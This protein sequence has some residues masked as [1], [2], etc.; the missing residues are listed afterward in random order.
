MIR[1]S[2]REVKAKLSAYL[3]QVERGEEVIILRR[4]KPVAVLKPVEKP[5]PLPS[6]KDFR[7]KMRLRGESASESIIRMR[8]ES[9]Y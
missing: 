5:A 9:R 8:E 1:T 6:L 4:G 7:E 2:I 3:S